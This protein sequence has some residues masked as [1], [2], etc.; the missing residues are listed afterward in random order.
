[1]AVPKTAVEWK[2]ALQEKV[3][4][5]SERFDLRNI[6][7][8]E[9]TV[10]LIP[11][12][13]RDVGIRLRLWRTTNQSLP[14]SFMI[15]DGGWSYVYHNETMSYDDVLGPEMLLHLYDEYI[16]TQ[17][18]ID[19]IYGSNIT[20]ILCKGVRVPVPIIPPSILVHIFTHPKYTTVVSNAL[21]FLNKHMAN[22]NKIFRERRINPE[23]ENAFRKIIIN[24]AC[25]RVYRCI[26]TQPAIHSQLV[27]ST[28]EMKQLLLLREIDSLL[29]KIDNVS[30]YRRTKINLIQKLTDFKTII[31][32]RQD[33]EGRV[34]GRDDPRA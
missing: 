4:K 32:S 8:H 28:R 12:M 1:M 10:R 24:M 27:K 34:L 19:V 15:D 26:P 30:I 2:M 5:R 7:L 21:W 13:S 25:E 22:N 33:D 9:N 23:E 16:T 29:L 18:L 31:F 14:T 6:L 17:T 3:Y 20:I 11:K